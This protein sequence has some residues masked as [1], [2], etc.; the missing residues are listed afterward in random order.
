MD[1]PIRKAEKDVKK[2]LAQVDRFYVELF[3]EVLEQLDSIKEGE[4]TLLDHSMITLGSG[5]GRWKRSHHG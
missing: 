3:A 1:S 5:V 4:G 2:I